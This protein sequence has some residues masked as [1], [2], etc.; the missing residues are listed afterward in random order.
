MSIES[1]PRWSLT[2]GAL[3]RLLERLHRDPDLAALEYEF[4]RRR[5]ITFFIVRKFEAAESLADEVIDR[6]ARRLEEGEVLEH[7]RAYFH[8]VAQRVAWERGKHYAREREAVQGHR[9]FVAGHAGPTG[10]TEAR[11]DC[12][13]RCLKSLPEE[14]RALIACYYDA[15]AVPTRDDRKRLAARLGISYASLKVRAHRIRGRLEQ[16]LRTCLEERDAR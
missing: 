2:Q 14:S 4:L 8:G 13:E 15:R 10:A 1:P 5:L 6:V 12:L 3:D 9:L 16:C 7:P 11:A